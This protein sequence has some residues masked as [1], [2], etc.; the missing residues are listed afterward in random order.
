MAAFSGLLPNLPV[1]G[2]N[3]NSRKNFLTSNFLPKLISRSKMQ[4]LNVIRVSKGGNYGLKFDDDEGFHEEP[5]LVHLVK[6]SMR[7]SK[8]LFDFLV[9]QPGQLKYIEWPSFKDTL[10]TAT[11]TLVLVALLIVALA[12]IDAALSFILAL[13]LRRPA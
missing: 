6:E 3:Y 10:R 12:S 11:L 1:L 5:Y 9:Q 7:G 8:E 13:L 2:Y 4:S